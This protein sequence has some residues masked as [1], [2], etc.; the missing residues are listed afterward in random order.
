MASRAFAQC[1]HSRCSVN[2]RAVH[3]PTFTPSA[4]KHRTLK[5]AEISAHDLCPALKACSI[6]A[7][8]IASVSWH[9]GRAVKTRAQGND[10]SIPDETQLNIWRNCQAVCFDVDC[11]IPCSLLRACF[12]FL[13]RS[14]ESCHIF[15]LVAPAVTQCCQEVRALSCYV[16]L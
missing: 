4:H 8:S 13:F 3:R 14:L 10:K 5:A 2:S 12:L 16:L 6:G 11:A 15:P 9:R 7:A 1:P